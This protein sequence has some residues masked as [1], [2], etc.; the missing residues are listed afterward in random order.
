[1]PLGV[2][3]MSLMITLYHEQ[4]LYFCRY[5]AANFNAHASHFHTGAVKNVLTFTCLTL[6]ISD[7]R[8]YYAASMSQ[9]ESSF[10]A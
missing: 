2:R 9:D 4:S 3:P 6:E 1:M 5:S 10:G 8:G 7:Y